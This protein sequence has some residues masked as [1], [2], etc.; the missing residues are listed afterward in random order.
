MCECSDFLL[1]QITEDFRMWDVQDTS[2]VA[3]SWEKWLPIRV[4][5]FWKEFGMNSFD[6]YLQFGWVVQ[7]LFCSPEVY[8]PSWRLVKFFQ[9]FPV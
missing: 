7:E 2:G 3:V 4:T 5:N 1:L 8:T 9:K 6:V